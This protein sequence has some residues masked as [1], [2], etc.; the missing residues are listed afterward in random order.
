[1]HRN[2]SIN[3]IPVWA[4]TQSDIQLHRRSTVYVKQFP[5]KEYLHHINLHHKYWQL[6]SGICIEKYSYNEYGFKFIKF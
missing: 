5:V 2:Q 4:L 3:L 1:M 6:L